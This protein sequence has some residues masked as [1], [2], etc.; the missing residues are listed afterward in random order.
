MSR[1]RFLVLCSLLCSS[2]VFA[3]EVTVTPP[4][5]EVTGAEEVSDDAPA[6][7][8]ETESPFSYTVF[9]D[10]Y[11]GVSSTLVSTGRSPGP[12][13]AFASENGAALAFAGGDLRY[14]SQYVGFALALRLG[15]AVP[16]LLGSDLI[17]LGT[18]GLKQAYL[19]VRPHPALSIDAGQFDTIYGAEV[20]ESWLNPT[21]SRG[22]LYFI[23]QPFFHTGI[24]VNANVTDSFQLRALAVQ[25]WNSVVDNNRAKSFGGQAAWSGG[26][27]SISAGYLGGAEQDEMVDQ[28]VVD[29]ANGRWR[30]LVDVVVSAEFGPMT[31]QFNGD[32]ITESISDGTSTA[33]QR[34]YGGMVAA[35]YAFA[36][37]A[38][39]ARAEVLRDEDG[40]FTGVPDLTLGTGTVTFEAEPTPGLVLR[41]EGRMDM[42]SEDVFAAGDTDVRDRT[43]RVLLG[44]VYHTGN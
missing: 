35:R 44:A 17:L 34:A 36:P 22:A 27:V 40:L 20:S 9:A 15:S 29:G 37:F 31:L 42:A 5:A 6:E 14:D 13:Y 1:S 18:M 32:F 30:H 25:G 28:A 38:V 10:A 11:A 26:G 43:F 41:L 3:Q 19:T 23:A 33:Q 2:T 7:D 24:R 16:A 39:A 12:S 8:A 4:S 21:Y